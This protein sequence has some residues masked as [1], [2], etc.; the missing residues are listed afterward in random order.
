[1]KEQ[2][3]GW[4]PSNR[5]RTEEIRQSLLLFLPSLPEQKLQIEWDAGGDQTLV[6]FRTKDGYV[7]FDCSI[8]FRDYLRDYFELPNAGEYYN[9]GGGVLIIEGQLL[10]FEYDEYAY[11]EKDELLYIEEHE[12]DEGIWIDFSHLNINDFFEKADKEKVH[13]YSSV[14]FV[15]EKETYTSIELY[16]KTIPNAWIAKQEAKLELDIQDYMQTKCT[17]PFRHAEMSCSGT[18]T[19]SG[20]QIEELYKIEYTVEKDKKQERV[21]LL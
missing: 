15:R 19:A 2:I 1:M 14:N 4:D 9:K 12:Y 5:K 10:V 20:I 11:F 21:N 13:F 3:W 18:I 8:A 16:G 17:M 6:N 7:D